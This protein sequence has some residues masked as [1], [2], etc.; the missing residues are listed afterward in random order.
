MPQCLHCS[1]RIPLSAVPLLVWQRTTWVS[2][3]LTS[4][5]AQRIILWDTVLVNSTSKSGRPICLSRPA[6][7]WVK[8]FALH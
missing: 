5:R 2:P 4:S 6:H 1:S 7:I 8:T 3:S